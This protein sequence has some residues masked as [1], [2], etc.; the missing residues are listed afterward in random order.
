MNDSVYSSNRFTFQ[1]DA[2]EGP[3]DLLLHLIRQ[4]DIDIFD[5]PIHQ[6]ADR[7]QEYIDGM[8]VLDLEMAGDYLSTAAELAQI[9]SKMLLPK[10]PQDEDDEEDPRSQLVQKL[11]AYEQV[12]KAAGFLGDRNQ[13]GR[14]VFLRGSDPSSHLPEPPMPTSD[15]PPDVLRNTLHQLSF[16]YT[17]TGPFHEVRRQVMSVRQRISWVCKHLRKRK[18]I[19]FSQLKEEDWERLTTIVTFL[20]LLE[21]CRLRKV[22]LTQLD[23][24]DLEMEAV[25]TLEELPL[26]DVE[27]FSE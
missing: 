12:Q 22:R 13:L 9:K 16:K 3:L 2:F 19:R 10:A 23:G 26:L 5:I 15:V 7:F 25:D 21:L 8:G 24:G 4:A 6:I 17:K 11:L 18:T 20:A 1:L 27:P 14:D